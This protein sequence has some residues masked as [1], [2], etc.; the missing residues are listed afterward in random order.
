MSA[1]DLAQTPTAVLVQQ[2]LALAR[3][4]PV[5]QS[6]EYWA[7]IRALHFRSGRDVFEEAVRL[8]AS[9]DPIPRAAGADILA[10]LGVL[11]AVADY[12]FADESAPI[13]VT[14]LAD[15]EPLVTA[16]ALYALGHLGRGEPV[17]L[18]RLA[19]HASEDVRCALA[20]ALGGRTD[21]TSV[22]TLI[23]LSADRDG[24]T[25][26]WATFA[27]GAR[28]EGDSPAI[29][30]ALAA[31]LTDVDDEVRGEAMA[32][33]ARRLD[34]RAVE[35]VLRE[36]AETNVMTFAI[37]AAGA[38]P[39]PEFLPHLE[40]LYAAHP[41]NET[42]VQAL[43]RCR[44]AGRDRPAAPVSGGA[45]AFMKA[46][47][48]VAL[49]VGSHQPGGA[50]A[51]GVAAGAPHAEDSRL[52]VIPK[53]VALYNCLRHADTSRRGHVL[54]RTFQ[55]QLRPRPQS[56]LRAVR[57]DR[58]FGG[59]APRQILRH[60]AQMPGLAPL[61]RTALRRRGCH[62]PGPTHSRTESH[63]PRTVHLRSPGQGQSVR[64]CSAM[65]RALRR[66]EQLALR[67]RRP[68]NRRREGA[69]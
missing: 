34:E 59:N 32:G 20:Y 6:D 66:H 2:T 9:P 5:V 52:C 16:S 17:D 4:E 27:L 50:A 19:S 63:G 58:R 35:P 64:P 40:A 67:C 49:G 23:A 26:N 56:T 31:R 47:A 38:M 8:C 25:R 53:P 62:G 14:L 43:S 33:L 21:R 60:E 37:E 30:D 3:S 1:D 61:L 15:R 10:Q 11:D 13:L 51:A 55:R 36:L 68:A 54:N 65:T 46:V 24:D 18:A 44:E 7:H 41:E 28:S 45:N 22:D 29:R 42:I 39:R 48:K 57:I 69:A 12:P